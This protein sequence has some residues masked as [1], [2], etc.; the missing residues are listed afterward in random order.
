M[1]TREGNGRR[2]GEKEGEREEGWVLA[3]AVVEN[4]EVS[5]R[6]LLTRQCT[7]YSSILFHQAL[8]FLLQFQSEEE[9]LTVEKSEE[10]PQV[11]NRLKKRE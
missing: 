3:R 8:L 10:I 1:T 4:V 11:R 9:I 2:E 5:H 7:C 6:Y